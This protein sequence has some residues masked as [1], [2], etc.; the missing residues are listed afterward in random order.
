MRQQVNFFFA[1]F[2]EQYLKSQQ[3][4][5]KKGKVAAIAASVTAALLLTFCLFCWF[6]VKK[7]KGKQKF[8]SLVI[9]ISYLMIKKDLCRRHID[10][11]LF[12]FLSC[13]L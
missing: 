5:G 12:L 8:Q 10:S 7:R 4:H 9:L 2:S 1:L 6:V 13:E 11:S 3:S